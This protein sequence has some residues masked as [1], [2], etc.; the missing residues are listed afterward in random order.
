MKKVLF[1]AAG[2][3]GVV[4]TSLAFKAVSGDAVYCFD[5]QAPMTAPSSATTP[6]EEPVLFSSLNDLGNGARYVNAY[7]T[8]VSGHTCSVPQTVFISQE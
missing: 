5:N 2:L 3:V 8:A 6:C 4:A 1:T 7:C